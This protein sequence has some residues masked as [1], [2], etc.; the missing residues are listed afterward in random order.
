MKGETI[1]LIPPTRRVKVTVCSSSLEENVS[2]LIQYIQ[3]KLPDVV[4]KV[5]FR[6]L[7]Y[8]IRDIDNFDLRGIDVL[9]LCHSINNR[10]FSITDVTD[11]LYDRFLPRAKKYLGKCKIGVIAHDFSEDY[12]KD[13]KIS[14]FRRTQPTTFKCAALVLIG[15]QLSHDPVKLNDKQLGDLQQFFLAS[16]AS[17]SERFHKM[18][19][20]FINCCM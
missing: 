13:F 3:Q 12:L 6:S 19:Y 17:R 20:R 9:L 18:P 8:N 15:G 1:S 14:T 5:E 16:N 11:A 10:R 2:G 7:P 4:E